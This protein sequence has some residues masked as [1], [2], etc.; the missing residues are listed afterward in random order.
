MRLDLAFRWFRHNK[1]SQEKLPYGQVLNHN[2]ILIDSINHI[3]APLH[4]DIT[5]R[6]H[7]NEYEQRL[8]EDY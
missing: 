2:S 6:P 1:I 4:S 5:E 3:N 8:E 7:P